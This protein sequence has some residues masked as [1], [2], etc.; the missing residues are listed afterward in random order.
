MNT[1]KTT[2][3]GVKDLL[4][5]MVNGEVFY[6]KTGSSVYYHE[7]KSQPIRYLQAN[8]RVSSPLSVGQ[9]STL[10]NDLYKPI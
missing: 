5:R 3:E 4:D 9:L 7:A 10:L 6:T 1:T 2:F 8:I